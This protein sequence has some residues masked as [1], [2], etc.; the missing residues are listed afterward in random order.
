MLGL[1]RKEK[2]TKHWQW[3]VVGKHPA[4]R[5]FFA[6]GS[7][8]LMAEALTDWIRRGAESLVNVSKQT[9]VR[10]CSW[11]FW[12]RTPQTGMLAC[13]I[14]RNSCDS[15]GRPFPL[16]V[17]GSGSLEDW[18]EYWELLPF[19]CEGVWSQMEQ[20]ASKNYSS[21]ELLEKDTQLLRQPQRRWEEMK[22]QQESLLEMIS[23]EADTLFS[24]ELLGENKAVF[25]PFQETGQYDFFAMISAAHAQQKK[26]ENPAPNSLFMG[27]LIDSP[28]IAIF[29]RPLS[30]QDF[31]QM[32]LT[33]TLK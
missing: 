30:G 23:P 17:M 1:G 11:R 19:S 31:E 3:D 25:V 33:G 24:S 15:V 29:K 13:G 20:L 12:A 28:R 6:L 5:D 18:E 14:I 27:G 2:T 21:F 8:S 22:K 26:R 9:L 4:A 32:W 16:L 7:R 10:S